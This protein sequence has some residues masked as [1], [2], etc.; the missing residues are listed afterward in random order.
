MYIFHVLFSSSKGHGRL[1]AVTWGDSAP[2]TTSPSLRV[3][4]IRSYDSPLARCFH[5]HLSNKTKSKPFSEEMLNAAFGGNFPCLGLL[6]FYKLFGH[7]RGFPTRSNWIELTTVSLRKA[8]SSHHFCWALVEFL[9]FLCIRVI[10]WGRQCQPLDKC[11]KRYFI[12]YNTRR[13][14]M[15]FAIPKWEK[16]HGCTISPLPNKKPRLLIGLTTQ[17]CWKRSPFWTP[18]T[19]CHT[20]DDALRETSS[21]VGWANIHT[22]RK[23]TPIHAFPGDLWVHVRSQVGWQVTDWPIFGF[24]DRPTDCG[25]YFHGLKY[26]T[27]FYI[28]FE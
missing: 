14:K 4:T 8:L 5:F 13:S 20:K 9:C 24:K 10:H 26:R 22:Q 11:Q 21:K 25:V 7:T 15:W 16:T 18:T 27:C 2:M 6:S 23:Q 19:P 1:L 28:S 3:V 12:C 17:V